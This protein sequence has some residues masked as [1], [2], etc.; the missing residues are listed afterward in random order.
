MV[1]GIHTRDNDLVVNVTKEKQL[2]NMR[3]SGTDENIILTPPIKFSL[4]QA[5][6]FIDDDELVEVTPYTIRI[7]KKQLLEHDR[8]K[9]SRAANSNEDLK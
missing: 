9:A 3:A 2:T 5:L 4:E 8:K 7:R 1:V 6:E